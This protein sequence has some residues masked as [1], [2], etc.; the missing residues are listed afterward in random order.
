MKRQLY[1]L[2]KEENNIR[3]NYDCCKAML[4]TN[5]SQNV[6]KRNTG[7]LDK[8][9]FHKGKVAYQTPG[10]RP[11]ALLQL[12]MHIVVIDNQRNLFIKKEL[13]H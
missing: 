13:S 1:K 5:V 10:S 6:S 9:S 11:M 7:I 4:M 12:G 2:S 8:D 3:N